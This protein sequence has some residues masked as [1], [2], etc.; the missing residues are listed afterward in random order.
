MLQHTHTYTHTLFK[1]ST[2]VHEGHCGVTRRQNKE[3][4]MLKCLCAKGKNQYLPVCN[5]AF[6]CQWEYCNYK[7]CVHE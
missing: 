7:L 5:A 1:L 3:R 4:N 6:N 2:K